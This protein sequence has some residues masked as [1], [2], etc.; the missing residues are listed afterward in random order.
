[1]NVT[2]VGL[3]V[4]GGAMASNL[5]AGDVD[6]TVY[7]RTKEKAAPLINQGA[8]LNESLHEAVE[9]ADLVFTM[10]TGPDAV[11]ET[12][13]GD[14]GF[15]QSMKPGSLWVDCSTVHPAFTK[16]CYDSALK[17]DVRFMDAPVAGTKGP[18]EQ[19]ELVFLLG[20]EEKD[21]N[22]IAPYTSIMGKKAVHVGPVSHG[23][24]LKM[25]VNL[26][27][28]TN[29]A[30][31]TE[32]MMLGEK[33]GLEKDFLLDTL[34]DMPVAAP[35]LKMKADKLRQ[36]NYDEEFSL[37]NMHKDLHL[38]SLSGFDHHAALKITNIV[39]EAFSEAN[40]N[41]Y[42]DLDFSAI[43]EYYRSLHNLEK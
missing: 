5:A 16:L 18:A 9:D 36:D 42:G 6:L 29:M 13:L 40:V 27:L 15:V 1:M 43:Y 22:E 25:V 28:A 31:F 38:A 4:M 2:F 26:M 19:G 35:F 11:Q 41:G 21:V 12:A 3:G 17:E 24:S 8:H 7:N 32:G 20:G 23:T 10:L 14:L 37:K 30:V 34:P 39:K 33:L